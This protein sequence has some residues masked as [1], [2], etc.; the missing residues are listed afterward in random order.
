MSALAS[1]I[2]ISSSIPHL[3]EKEKLLSDSWKA[4]DVVAKHDIE[5]NLGRRNYLLTQQE[6]NDIHVS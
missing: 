4:Q 3:A 5:V 2:Q 1:T 6:K